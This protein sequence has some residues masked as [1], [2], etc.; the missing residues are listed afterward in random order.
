M[1][2]LELN[3]M[4]KIEAGG[5]TLGCATGAWAIGMAVMAAAAGPVGWVAWG[6]MIGTSFAGGASMGSCIYNW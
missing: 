3:Q 2:T 6:A 1:K 5:F 4:E